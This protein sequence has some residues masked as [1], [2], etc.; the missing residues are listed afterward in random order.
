MGV[1]QDAKQLREA[2]VLRALRAAMVLA[3]VVLV[4]MV[5][6]QPFAVARIA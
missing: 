6:G 3:T 2:A 4:L 1:K 5:F